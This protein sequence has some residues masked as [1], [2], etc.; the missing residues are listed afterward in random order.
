MKLN[1]NN[2]NDLNNNP[3]FMFYKDDSE[4]TIIEWCPNCCYEVKIK[5]KAEKQICPMCGD[6]IWPCSLYDHNRVNCFECI[7]K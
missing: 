6:D 1:I 7:I 2:S 4:E 5:N 3:G